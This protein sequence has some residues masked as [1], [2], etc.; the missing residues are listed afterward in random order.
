M[1]KSSS[2]ELCHI[3]GTSFDDWLNDIINEGV[4]YHLA[5]YDHIEH[6]FESKHEDLNIYT[7]A[8][9]IS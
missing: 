9:R 4:E 7:L 2:E 1:A 6:E 8:Y 3:E 5:I